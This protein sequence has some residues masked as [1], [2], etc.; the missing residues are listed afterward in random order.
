MVVLIS[1]IIV[2]IPEKDIRMYCSNCGNQIDDNAVVCPKCGCATQS[3]VS[4]NATDSIPS[5]V[6]TAKTLG[7]L[8]IILGILIPI[9]GLICGYIGKG[10]AEPYYDKFTDAKEG[11]DKCEIGIK[12]A[13]AFIILGI[14]AGL[15]YGFAVGSILY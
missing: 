3:D 1:T 11:F 8:S 15:I 5:D 13:W 2:C 14:I 12:I 4:V 10:K 6:S 9:V 7:L